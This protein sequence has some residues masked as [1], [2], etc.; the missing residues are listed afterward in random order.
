[1]QRG[2][3]LR[4]LLHGIASKLHH[5]MFPQL[6]T[7]W[8]LELFSHLAA[9]SATAILQWKFRM[10]SC[11]E[12]VKRFL[13]SVWVST[14]DELQKCPG[15]KSWNTLSAESSTCKAFELTAMKNKT[16]TPTCTRPHA[17]NALLP[18]DWDKKGVQACCRRDQQVCHW[19]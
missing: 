18:K 1:M 9:K 4:H 19:F 12:V 11:L 10:Q 8:L 7:G 15:L 5:R 13:G 3:E 2:L 17:S 6:R 16:Q 14:E